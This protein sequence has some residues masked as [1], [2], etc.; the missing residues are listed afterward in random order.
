[1][2]GKSIIMVRDCAGN[3]KGEFVAKVGLPNPES[4][5]LEFVYGETDQV[6]DYHLQFYP[7]I[8]VKT[9]IQ[10]MGKNLD[11][12]FRRNDMYDGTPVLSISPFVS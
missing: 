10:V 11:S 12:C 7:V 3:G 8:P 1:M 4:F 2:E 6:V 9:G 5:G